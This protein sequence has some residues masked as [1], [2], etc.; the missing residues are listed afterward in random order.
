[1]DLFRYRTHKLFDK[2]ETSL[3]SPQ[4][5]HSMYRSQIQSL[6]VGQRIWY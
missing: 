3:S 6:F 1:M 5:T 2:R 4:A